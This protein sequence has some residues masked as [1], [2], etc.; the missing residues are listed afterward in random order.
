MSANISEEKAGC[1][2]ELEISGYREGEEG[3][4]YIFIAVAFYLMKLQC[5]MDIDGYR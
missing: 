5:N 4:H 3:I 2:V 1:G